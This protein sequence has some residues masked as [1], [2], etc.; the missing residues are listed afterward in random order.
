[1]TI[2]LSIFLFLDEF[3]KHFLQ[4]VFLKQSFSNSMSH[5]VDFD[6]HRDEITPV[7]FCN[8]LYLKVNRMNINTLLEILVYRFTKNVV[9]ICIKKL[10]P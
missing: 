6:R 4:F 3:F 10:A 1:M 7:L 2:F 8:N 5:T 9:K